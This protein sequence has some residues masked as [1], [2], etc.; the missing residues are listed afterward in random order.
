MPEPPYQPPAVPPKEPPQEPASPGRR[1]WLIALIIVVVIALV[2]AVAY[3]VLPRFLASSPPS[4]TDTLSPAPPTVSLADTPPP[5]QISPLT[6]E[7]TNGDA[8]G[9]ALCIKIENSVDARPQLGLDAADIVYEE[10]VEGGISRFMAVFQSNMPSQVEPVRSLR[11]MD[12]PLAL[13]LGCAL[14]FSGGQDPF[15]NAAKA[16]GLTLIYQD[17][18]DLGFSRD[19]KRAAP[20]N[21]I[22]DIPTFIAKAQ[23]TNLTAP[24]PPFL[25][26]ATGDQSSAAQDGNPVSKLSLK[27]S[28]VA[29]PNW[30]WDEATSKWLRYEGGKLAKVVGGAT[31]SA[32]NVVALSVEVR[33]TKY[34]DPAGNPVPE[35]QVVGQG[36]GVLAAGGKV[37]TIN[38]SKSADN[39]PFVFTD[40]TGAPVTLTPGNTWIELVPTSGTITQVP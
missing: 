39:Q 3:V 15:V 2:A 8:S 37:M 40:A 11:P 18:G 13:P 9:P 32:T 27:L 28:S 7:Q 12:P 21:V 36:T 38:W 20:H 31:I 17:R 30:Q 10:I 4:V 5:I 6:G 1:W 16:T 33:N 22:G 24:L 14:V 26:P 34:K 19:S 35:T 29:Q 23:Q 25:F